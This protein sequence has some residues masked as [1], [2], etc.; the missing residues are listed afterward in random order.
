VLAFPRQIPDGPSGPVADLAAGIEEGLE[1]HF[2]DRLVRIMWAMREVVFTPE[3]LDGLWLRTFP[4]AQVTR[5]PDAGHY[6]QED[7]H[8]RIVPEL[9][10]FLAMVPA[11][12]QA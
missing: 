9:L 3:T 5:L 8:E 6:L 12:E 10:R 2:R 4:D 7:A 11:P 1:R